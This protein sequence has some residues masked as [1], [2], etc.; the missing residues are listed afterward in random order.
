LSIVIIVQFA[1]LA[2]IVGIGVCVVY[3]IFEMREVYAEQQEKLVRAIAAVEEFHKVRPEF[4]S[5]LQRVESDGHALQTI[6]M[7][8]EGAV[9]AL[10]N[11]I[12][13]SVNGA[14]D[15]QTAVIEDLRDHIDSQEEG[16]AKIVERLSGNL[17]ALPQPQPAMPPQAHPEPKTE[18][19]DYLR[20]RK[21]IVSGDPC[22]RFSILKEWISVNLLAILHR[23][24]RGWNT[25]TDLIAN[26]PGYLEAEAEVLNGCVL[27]IGTHGHAQKLAT[28]I[29]DVE[30]FSEL[31]QWFAASSHGNGAHL[32]PAVLIRSN[33]HF[34]LISKGSAYEVV[35]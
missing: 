3:A 21:E 24:S 34:E 9:A 28:P 32:S 6:A 23:A 13:S 4:I 15:R 33:D 31:S 11:T 17:P 29:R 7:Q 14:A 12:S 30:P 16:L 27:I 10:Q 2:V 19:G 25:A 22:I 20:L 5:L 1:A 35:S 26:I 8:I 18:S